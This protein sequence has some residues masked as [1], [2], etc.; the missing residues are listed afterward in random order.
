MFERTA[1]CKRQLVVVGKSHRCQVYVTI[2][3][4][5]LRYVEVSTGSIWGVIR[6]FELQSSHTV[7]SVS[8]GVSEGPHSC[9]GNSLMHWIETPIVEVNICVSACAIRF[10]DWGL[11]RAHSCTCE[12]VSSGGKR[13]KGCRHLTLTITYWFIICL[14]FILSHSRD[15]LS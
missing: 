7:S 11:R 6:V 10:V 5:I 14:K 1:S 9:S 12:V 8:S 3:R 4:D 13:A 15:E 2:M